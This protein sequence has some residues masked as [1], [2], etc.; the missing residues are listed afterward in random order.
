MIG[1][2]GGNFGGRWLF[3]Y[4]AAFL[5]DFSVVEMCNPNIRISNLKMVGIFGG[6]FGGGKALFLLTFFKSLLW[7]LP[8]FSLA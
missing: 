3:S 4:S 2:F 8:S 7:H 1:I 5:V 6:I